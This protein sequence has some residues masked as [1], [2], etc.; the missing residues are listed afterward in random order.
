M[1]LVVEDGTIVSGAE[2]YVTVADADAYFLK[3]N[4]SVW[5][6]LDVEDKEAGLRAATQ[7]IDSTYN[8]IGCLVSNQQPI[9]WPRTAAIDN[10]GRLLSITTI[11][12]RLKDATCEAALQHNS[13]ALLASTD[14]ETS[15]EKVGSIEVSYFQGQNSKKYPLVNVLLKDLVSGGAGKLTRV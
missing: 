7:Y 12:Q 15:S 3:L 1:S 11:P 10:A 13:G 4:N 6:A 5:D 8:F 2:S 9:M 14:R